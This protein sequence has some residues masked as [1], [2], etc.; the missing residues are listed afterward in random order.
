M[1]GSAPAC[2]RLSRTSHRGAASV[3]GLRVRLCAEL[4]IVATILTCPDFQV[5]EQA[6]FHSAHS[7]GVDQGHPS[8]N[9]GKE[10]PKTRE[11]GAMQHHDTSPSILP[12]L[13]LALLSSFHPSIHPSIPPSLRPSVRPS[14]HHPPECAG[15]P[16]F[17]KPR[18]A[19]ANAV[20]SRALSGHVR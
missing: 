14:T 7:N 2:Y 10:N 17:L 11:I 19:L 8:M 3:W 13:H 16:P 20:P 15:P 1:L 9:V 4:Q 5:P 12:S 18:C 6:T